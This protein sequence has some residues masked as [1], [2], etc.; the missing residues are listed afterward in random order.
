[1]YS[2]C[3]AVLNSSGNWQIIF[4]YKKSEEHLIIIYSEIKQSN[5]WVFIITY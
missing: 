2:C 5:K 1:M 3:K 4:H